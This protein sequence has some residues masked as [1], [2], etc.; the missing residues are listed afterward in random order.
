M[1]ESLK[2]DDDFVQKNI[3]VRPTSG[4]SEVDVEDQSIKELIASA[5]FAK[6]KGAEDSVLRHQ[7]QKI[8]PLHRS[9][10]DWSLKSEET[11]QQ[12]KADI[13]FTNLKEYV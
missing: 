7:S 4:K 9:C 3:G 11:K 2:K 10:E 5:L 12:T 6:W 1:A 8:F 13:T